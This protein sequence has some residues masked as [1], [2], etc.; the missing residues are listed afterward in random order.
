MKYL[1]M[2]YATQNDFAMMAGRPVPEQ[3]PERI[4]SQ[5]QVQEMHKF[6]LGF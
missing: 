4:M 6:M 5:D 3:P 1:I 2:L